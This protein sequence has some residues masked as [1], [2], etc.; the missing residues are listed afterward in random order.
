MSKASPTRVY[1]EYDEHR[2]GGKIENP[3]EQFSRREDTNITVRFIRL[4]KSQPAHRFFNHSI[5]LSNP[6]MI[7][8]DKLFVA[9]VRYSDGDTFG[10]TNG[11]WYIAGVA[12]T[13]KIAS[14]MLKLEMTPSGKSEGIKR[15][16]GYFSRLEGTEVHELRLV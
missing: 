5:E 3:S 4:H 14:E 2:T 8:L 6:K 13:Y 12:P 11:N 1:V 10:R 7:D 16:E 9:V 15:W